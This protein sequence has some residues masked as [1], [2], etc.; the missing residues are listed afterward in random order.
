MPAPVTRARSLSVV[1]DDAAPVEGKP[2]VYKFR[3]N[4]GEFDRYQDRL[5]VKGWQ[6]ES[7]NANPVIL[8][9]HDASALPVGKGK[10]YLEGD[11]LMVDVEFDQNDAFAKQVESKVDGGYLNAVSVRYLMHDYT[12]NAKGGFDCAA[13]EL[14][15]ISVVT[16]PGNQRA[17]RVKELET[18]RAELIDAV[19]KKVV[20]ILDERDAKKTEPAPEPVPAVQ[21]TL[22][23]D[24]FAKA[25]A[26]SILN[27]MKERK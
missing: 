27:S 8:L 21:P 10:A 15:E 25:A 13:Q 20:T 3:A 18:E 5:S 19:A 26:A 17:V 22:D 23:V 6:L 14:L 12:E 4:D 9:N 1:K 24:A 11:A 16:I 7:F 2:K